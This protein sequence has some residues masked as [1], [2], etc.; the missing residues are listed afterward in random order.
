MRALKREDQAQFERL[1]AQL[2]RVGCRVTELD[3]ALAS[4][5]SGHGNLKQA[6]RLIAL[7]REAELFHSPDTTA[8]ADLHINGHQ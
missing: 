6:D 8:F 3:E 2:K 5:R 4:G 7:A 1:R